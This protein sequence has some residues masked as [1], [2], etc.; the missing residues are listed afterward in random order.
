[1]IMYDIL[2]YQISGLCPSPGILNKNGYVS[3]LSWNED[4][5]NTARSVSKS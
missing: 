3:I 1:M 2:D 5:T 4:E